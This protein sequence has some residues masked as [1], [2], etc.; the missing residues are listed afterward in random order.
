MKKKVRNRRWE[1][2]DFVYKASYILHLGDEQ[3]YVDEV[4]KLW[5]ESPTTIHTS[6]A[7]C[8]TG[9]AEGNF[10]VALW[11]QP[12]CDYANEWRSAVAAHE[13]VHAANS[14]LEERGIKSNSA[15]DEPLAYYVEY[16]TRECLTRLRE[17]K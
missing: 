5:P 7:R 9:W 13:A 2:F 11:F 12:G 3:K 10:T 8:I 14:V 17:K 1:W 16:I 6:A 4:N 15:I